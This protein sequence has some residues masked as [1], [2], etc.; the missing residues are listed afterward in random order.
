MAEKTWDQL[1]KTFSQARSDN[2]RHLPTGSANPKK[3]DWEIIEKLSFLKEHVANRPVVSSLQHDSTTKQRNSQHSSSFR[4]DMSNAILEERLQHRQPSTVVK[5]NLRSELASYAQI[6]PAVHPELDQTGRRN[7]QR[8]ASLLSHAEEFQECFV[9]I[10]DSVENHLKNPD[11][12]IFTDILRDEFNMIAP[13][14][15]PEVYQQVAS[16]LQ[17][18]KNVVKED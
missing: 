7:L 10:R 18:L 17:N 16:S 14:E 13:D 15:R 3:T 11:H 4:S 8:R 2:P 5:K 12:E 6:L 1:K 9:A